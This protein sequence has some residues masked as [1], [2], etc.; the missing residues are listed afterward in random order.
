MHKYLMGKA[1][2]AWYSTIRVSY[3]K[4]KRH[5]RSTAGRKVPR[6]G[7]CDDAFS[8][9]SDSSDRLM[10][11]DVGFD[12]TAEDNQFGLPMMHV[13]PHLDNLIY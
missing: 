12:S 2:I 10:K 1:K 3:H 8:P 9:G 4:V 11:A 6:A 7:K 13:L 5:T